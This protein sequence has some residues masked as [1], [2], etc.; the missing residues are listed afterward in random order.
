MVHIYG[1]NVILY[2]AAM[3]AWKVHLYMVDMESVK[4]HPYMANI[5]RSTSIC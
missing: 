1:G 5:E 4:E 2:L 3:E